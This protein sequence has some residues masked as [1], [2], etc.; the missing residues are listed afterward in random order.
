MGGEDSIQYEEIECWCKEAILEGADFLFDDKLFRFTLS[1][2]AEEWKG[3]S[4]ESLQSLLRN[5]H[6]VHV[7]TSAPRIKKNLPIYLKA[8][9]NGESITTISKKANFSPFLL[10]RYMV[11]EMTILKS[12]KKE[13]AKI[14][15]DPLAEL[16]S[17][18]ILEEFQEAEDTL[19]GDKR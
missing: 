18:T 14:M 16:S 7:K 15:R 9:R 4:V 2:K 5:I 1:K 6:L 11:Q 10:S 12:G 17:E 19:L 13:L 8:Y 3:F